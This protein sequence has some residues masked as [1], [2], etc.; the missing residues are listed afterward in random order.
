MNGDEQSEQRLKQQPMRE[1][2]AAW[3]EEILSA[4][5]TAQAPAPSRPSTLDP[6]PVWWRELFWPNPVAWGALAAIWL[7]ICGANFLT[8]EPMSGSLANRNSKPSPQM[9]EQLRL[10]DQ[11][12][13]ELV[14]PREPLD[15]ERP[16]RHAPR[17]SR[18][19]DFFNV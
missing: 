4:A 13:A 7:V 3:R 5:R 16:K 1:V 8:R 19:E 18:R 14:G 11:M 2:P 10:Q 12:L 9:R 15:A 17:S 6:R